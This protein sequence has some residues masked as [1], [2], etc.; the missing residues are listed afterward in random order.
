MFRNEYLEKFERFIYY[1]YYE[2]NIYKNVKSFNHLMH[3]FW[4][5]EKIC[6]K[7]WMK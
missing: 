6:Q 2:L 7:L 5:L 4:N 1:K 3:V